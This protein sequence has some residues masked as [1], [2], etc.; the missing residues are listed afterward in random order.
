MSKGQVKKKRNTG[1]MYEFLVRTISRALIADDS[2][3][4]ALAL[5]ILK[6]HFRPGTELHREFKLF[7]SLINTTVSSEA[8]AAGI[9]SEAR[10]A[11]RQ[12]NIDQLEREK[13]LLIRDINHNF[14]S[15]GFYDQPMSEYKTYATIATLL[16]DWRQ[17][18]PPDF[19]RLA[20]YEDTLV[21]WLVSE[22]KQQTSAEQTTESPG[23]NRLVV[24][25]MTKKLNDKYG[26]ALNQ[27][28]KTIVK[29]FALYNTSGNDSALKLV[30]A[31]IKDSLNKKLSDYSNKELSTFMSDKVKLVKEDLTKETLDVLDEATVTRFMLYSKLSSEISSDEGGEK[32]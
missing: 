6:R 23:F 11:A 12:Y 5:K 8:V 15:D 29:E 25:L 32:S 3:K 14:A 1:L 30:L 28:Q 7:N 9:V 21:K 2:A 31:E 10:R 18:S 20:Q 27:E 4:S 19:S 26:N 22:K 13:S 24:K 16:S 17:D